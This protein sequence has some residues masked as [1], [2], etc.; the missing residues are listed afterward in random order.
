MSVTISGGG[1]TIKTIQRGTLAIPNGQ[2]NNT[3]I[4]AQVDPQKSIVVES[5]T[6]NNDSIQMLAKVSIINNGQEVNAGRT[7]TG[8]KTFISYQVIEYA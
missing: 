4:I 5:Q 2:T 3:V 1:S 8:N 6:S 7:V